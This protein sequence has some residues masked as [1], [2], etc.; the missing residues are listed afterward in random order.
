MKKIIIALLAL[1]LLFPTIVNAKE[2]TIDIYLFYSNDCPH[3]EKEMAYLNDLEKDNDDIKINLYEVKY[4]KDN[5]SLLSKV[6]KLIDGET[7][8]IP[9]TVIGSKYRVG[10]SN[11]TK[12]EIE[13]L[14]DGYRN[15]KYIDVVG[16]IIDG[17]ITDAN[18]DSVLN[19][20]EIIE[21]DSVSVPILGKIDPKKVSI[22]LIAIVMGLV[23]GF[24]PCAMW[25]LIFLISMLLNM[26]DKKKMWTLGLVF[27][28]TSAFVYLGFMVAWLNIVVRII[29]LK[30]IQ[31]VIA[32]VAL[33]GAGINL[34][35]YYRER[36]KDAGCEVIDDKKRKKMFNKIRKFTSEKSYI[37]AILGVIGLAISVNIVELACSAGLPVL[38]ANIL[39]INN[40]SPTMSMAYMLIYIFFFLL[41]DLIVFTIAMI[42]LKLTGVTTKYSKFTHLI[43]GIIMLLIGLLLIFKP[44]W[45]M[46]NF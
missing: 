21:D 5:N 12:M 3:C 34:R 40:L 30:W 39:A 43:G 19:K 17:S 37:L 13:K 26:K 38:F 31:I 29:E 28:F 42:T 18:I 22:P 7:P 14:I 9:Y 46:F 23:D 45:I 36:K 8:Y 2:K 33:I 15:G 25:V 35:S 6:Q 11:S 16:G 1:F 4:N 27:L 24:N 20:E 44:E 10:F 41:D 32:L